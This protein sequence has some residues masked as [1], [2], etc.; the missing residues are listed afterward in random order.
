MGHSIVGLYSMVFFLGGDGKDCVYL[1]CASR[2]F[3]GIV[4]AYDYG[5]GKGVFYGN[6]SCPINKNCGGRLIWWVGYSHTH[7]F[8]GFH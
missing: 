1:L 8:K 4:V 3:W 6:H 7:S 5:C 2:I